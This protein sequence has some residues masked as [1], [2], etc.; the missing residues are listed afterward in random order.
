MAE[1]F[2]A[3]MTNER[4]EH[5]LMD[6]TLADVTLI[7]DRNLEEIYR[8]V[9]LIAGERVAAQK[10][11]EMMQL[12]SA[13]ET[14]LAS[15]RTAH[16]DAIRA[17]LERSAES[18]QAEATRSLQLEGELAEERRRAIDA[19]AAVQRLQSAQA[20]RI[21]L[22]VAQCRTAGLR[23]AKWARVRVGVAMLFISVV[24]GLLTAFLPQLFPH[25][26]F[27]VTVVLI[28]LTQTFAVTNYL[29]FPD[30][31]LD[32]YVK[33]CQENAVARRATE[34]GVEQE[35]DQKQT[36]LAVSGLASAARDNSLTL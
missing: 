19:E 13:H 22:Q 33:Q 20:E 17:T 32:G 18:L 2:D 12:R 7:T 10:N 25:Q 36:D 34:L 26:A 27:V 15:Q 6:R 23:A 31:A 29:I 30:A 16:D 14:E 5:F 4:A 9:E 8:D 1:R 35:E 21:A 28:V 11:A 24:L 3:L